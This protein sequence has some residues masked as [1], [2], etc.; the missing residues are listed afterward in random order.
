MN[1]DRMNLLK[2]ELKERIIT[3]KCDVSNEEDVKKAMYGTVDAWGSIH[4]ALAVA[5]VLMPVLTHSS[6]GLMD[7]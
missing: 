1:E 2:N 6:K 5:G 3:F 7:V 4:V